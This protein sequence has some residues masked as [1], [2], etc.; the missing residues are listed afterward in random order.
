VGRNVDVGMKA[1]A[2]MSNTTRGR[3]VLRIRPALPGFDQLDPV[4]KTPP[5]LTRLGAGRDPRS[6][7][8]RREQSERGL[9]FCGTG[10]SAR[11]EHS[12][13]YGATSIRIPI[14]LELWPKPNLD[15]RSCR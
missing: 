15:R 3:R 1:H 14:R 2:A 6:N 11:P 4:A 10:D 5:A 8:R 13:K 9:C 12:G 7:R